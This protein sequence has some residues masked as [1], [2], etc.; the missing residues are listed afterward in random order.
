MLVLTY[1][2]KFIKGYWRMRNWKR[3]VHAFYEVYKEEVPLFFDLILFMLPL[4][5]AD[6]VFR[7]YES[8]TEILDELETIKLVTLMGEAMLL[9]LDHSF[10]RD[11]LNTPVLR[12]SSELDC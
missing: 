5:S 10:R 4:F 6:Q 12:P 9:S 2:R 1:E 7:D 11:L 3:P 8:Y